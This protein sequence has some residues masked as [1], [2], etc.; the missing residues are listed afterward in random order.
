MTTVDLSRQSLKHL[1]EQA[2][3]EMPEVAALIAPNN[4]LTAFCLGPPALPSLVIIDLSCNN[5]AEFPSLE[6]AP[7]CR[8]LYLGHNCI[9]SL[10]SIPPLP[11]LRA[12]ELQ[13]NR[14]SCLPAFADSKALETLCLS[15]NLIETIADGTSFGTLQQL[16]LFGNALTNLDAV[17]ALVG[18]CAAL[19]R[20][21][22][23]ANPCTPVALPG[24][25]C[26]PCAPAHQWRR[27]V[28]DA[29]P[30]LRW[31]DGDYISSQERQPPPAAA[32]LHISTRVMQ[33]LAA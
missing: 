20:V 5:L 9:A 29:G 18:R 22:L 3:R 15:C 11:C 33:Q 30:N 28:I 26:A 7:Q 4:Y 8:Q 14:L 13:H 16:G 25:P 27:R 31:L 24:V 17:V 23:G 19:Q 32:A 12:L 2:V 1:P 10:E 21:V 6:G